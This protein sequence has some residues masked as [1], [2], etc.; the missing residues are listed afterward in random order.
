LPPELAS[1]KT[2]P[3]VPVLSADHEVPFHLATVSAD[4]PPAVVKT[5][6][7]HLA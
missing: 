7:T 2:W 4:E 1:A 5:S 6:K 3:S